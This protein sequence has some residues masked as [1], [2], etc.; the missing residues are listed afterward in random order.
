[1]RYSALVDTQS[2]PQVIGA[3]C[4]RIRT[5]HGVSQAQLAS[6]AR[7]LGLHWTATKVGDFE[8]GRSKTPFGDVL[9]LVLA[10]DNAIGQA[11]GPS[12][13]LHADGTVTR[14]KR[15]RV[16]LADLVQWDGYV[17]L[18]DSF[19]PAGSAVAAVCSGKKWDLPSGADRAT[20]EQMDELLSPAPGV[21]GEHGMK[22]GDE[23]DMRRRSDVNERRVCKRLGID[24]DTL[25]AL[26]FTLWQGRTFTEERDRRAFANPLRRGQV[27]RELRAELEKVMA[28]GND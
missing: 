22:V 11:P 12:S 16:T 9:T 1:L 8:S 10:L 20:A 25:I 18:T 28:D 7:R 15:S 2:L 14:R 23:K 6:H 3:N 5:D 24:A 27:A 4:R 19:E 17:Q 26:S 13:V 21:L